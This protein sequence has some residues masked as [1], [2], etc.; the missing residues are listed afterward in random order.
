MCDDCK[1]LS[2]NLDR[3]QTRILELETA[4]RAVLAILGL[5]RVITEEGEHDG[6]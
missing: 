6:I 2:D 1:V 3:A 5:F 4:L